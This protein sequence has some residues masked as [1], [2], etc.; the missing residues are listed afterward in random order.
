M[1]STPGRLVDTA[2]GP[3]APFSAWIGALVVMA[4]LAA[5]ALVPDRPVRASSMD[6]ASKAAAGQAA[7]ST[8]VGVSS[9]AEAATASTL[10]ATVPLRKVL[11][12]IWVTAFSLG[13]MNTGTG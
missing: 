3:T 11:R 13:K 4:L 7:A 8:R 1:P 6:L 10:P 5:A 9:P 12:F 2:L